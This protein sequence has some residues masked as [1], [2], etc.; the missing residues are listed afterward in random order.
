MYVQ[1]NYA[2]LGPPVYTMSE[3]P[4]GPGQPA[5]AYMQAAYPIPLAPLPQ[6]YTSAY[7][8]S[9]YCTYPV[10]ATTT[11]PETA[12]RGIAAQQPIKEKTLQQRVDPKI[13]AIMSEHKADMLSQ[14]ISRLTYKV[15]KLSN[16][17]E[18]N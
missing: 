10:G 5:A 13:E 14:Q 11:L 2:P 6:G 18:H 9:P 16:S 7:A 17:I 4:Q 12:H 1:A 8:A 3:Y 15:Q